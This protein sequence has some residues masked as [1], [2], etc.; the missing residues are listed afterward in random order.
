MIVFLKIIFIWSFRE[1]GKEVRKYKDFIPGPTHL[2]RDTP[3]RRWE[4]IV[5]KD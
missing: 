4:S 5:E 3:T 1:P 2:S